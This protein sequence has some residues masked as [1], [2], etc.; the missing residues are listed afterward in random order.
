MGRKLHLEVVE[1]DAFIAILS[2]DYVG[3]CVSNT[4]KRLNAIKDFGPPTTT[5]ADPSVV[6]ANYT[7]SSG[8]PIRILAV[9]VWISGVRIAINIPSREVGPGAE[10]VGYKENP[11]G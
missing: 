1:E 2:G 8:C 11:R 4:P 6:S 9:D 10:V 3:D 7:F 5:R